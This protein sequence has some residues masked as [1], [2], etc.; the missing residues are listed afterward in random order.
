MKPFIF[1]ERNGHPHPRSRPVAVTFQEALEFLRDTVAGGGKVLFVGTKRQAQAPIRFEA[2]ALGSVLREQ[3]LA[4]RHAHELPHGPEVRRALQGAARDPRERGEGVGALE[5]R[6]R[7]HGS[8]GREV[9]AL[10]RRHPGHGAPARRDVR[11]RR[12]RRAHRDRRG[13]APRDSDRRGGGHQL[14]SRRRR[15]RV[16]GNDDAIRAI[17]L[18][19]ARVAEVVHRGRPHPQ[20][21]APV[22]GQRTASRPGTASARQPRR[23]PVAWWSRSSIRRAAGG[24]ER[25]PPAARGQAARE[26]VVA[27]LAARP[28]RRWSHR[29]RARTPRLEPRTDAA[30]DAAER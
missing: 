19:C 4:R 29:H 24:A 18:Y 9:P 22:P 23:P 12:E 30:R 5:A 16:P 13:A 1:G 2:R 25:I 8:R 27:A 15:L 26:A 6:P 20:R 14:Q 7:P 17:Q 10:A 3:P 11:D 28:S 21:E